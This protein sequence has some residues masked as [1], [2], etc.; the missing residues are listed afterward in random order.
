ML[1]R[2]NQVHSDVPVELALY[3][4]MSGRLWCDLVAFSRRLELSFLFGAVATPCHTHA[5][6]SLIRL[7]SASNAYI[8]RTFSLS[9][10]PLATLLLWGNPPGSKWPGHLPL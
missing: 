7:F 6:G 9:A 2:M 5:A 10:I 4:F 8:T 1:S 3:G